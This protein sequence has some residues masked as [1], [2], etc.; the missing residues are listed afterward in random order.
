MFLNL[1]TPYIEN[2]PICDGTTHRIKPIALNRVIGLALLILEYFDFNVG[3][4]CITIISMDNEG[5]HKVPL[6]RYDELN[7]VLTLDG[8]LKPIDIGI[9]PETIETNKPVSDW[10]ELIAGLAGSTPP[11]GPIMLY[12]DDDAPSGKPPILCADD[13][14]DDGDIPIWLKERHRAIIT[15]YVNGETALYKTT[16]EAGETIFRVISYDSLCRLLESYDFIWRRIDGILA[17]QKEIDKVLEACENHLSYEN[18]FCRIRE[19]HRE[20]SAYRSM[21]RQGPL[22]P[23]YSSYVHRPMDY[24]EPLPPYYGSYIHRYKVEIKGG[25]K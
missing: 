13:D 7:R 12:A 17:S 19:I 14:D 10:P 1:Q 25:D 6:L 11:N 23:Y 24:Q 22:P 21:N 18:V 2:S 20:N 3:A 8:W 5:F 4:Q 16:N 9:L 15:L